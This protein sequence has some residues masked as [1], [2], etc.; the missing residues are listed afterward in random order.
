MHLLALSFVSLS[1]V[2]LGCSAPSDC[3]QCISAKPSGSAVVA[4]TSSAPKKLS[5]KKHDREVKTL[6]LEAIIKTIPPEVVKQYDPYYNKEKT[7]RAVPLARVIEIGFTNEQGLPTQEYVLRALDGYTVPLHGNKV[8]EAGAYLAFEDTEVAGWE[9]IGQQRANPGPFYLIWAKKDQTDLEGHPRPYQ[10][11]SIQ[12]ADFD[13]VF[14]F[15]VPTGA[16]ADSPARRGFGIF[17]NQCVHCHAVNRQGGRVGPELNVPRSIVEY[18]PVD[19]IKAYIK[20]PLDF[21]Y[22]TMPPHPTLTEADLDGVIAYFTA[23]KDLKH[24]DEKAPQPKSP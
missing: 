11:A 8:F 12:I 10:L 7:Y 4:D 16:T 1:L 22:S 19:Q 2:L 6:D 9:P 23:M 24:D 3:P 21:R 17:Q 15:T 14:P 18:R 20:N 5:F 13:E